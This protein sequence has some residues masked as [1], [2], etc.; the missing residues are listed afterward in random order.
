[1]ITY[2]KNRMYGGFNLIKDYRV[3]VEIR[4]PHAVATRS[5]YVH[6]NPEGWLT[7]H[8][9]YWWDGASKP[10]IQTKNTMR[11]SLIHD[12]LYGL[13]RQRK[14]KS[15]DRADADDAF[16]EALLEDGMSRF[17]AWVFLKGVKRFAKFAI[18]FDELEAP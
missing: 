12:A 14:L 6:L 11:P 5:G 10:A 1:M 9:G 18:K 15:K 13:L 4:P 7:I 3:H 17:R 16:Y 2:I 8:A